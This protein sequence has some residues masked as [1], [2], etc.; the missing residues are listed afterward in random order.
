M[1]RGFASQ[2]GKLDRTKGLPL[3]RQIEQE[4]RER[5]HRGQIQPGQTLPSIRELTK[6]F[7]V[8]HLT[9]R[10]ALRILGEQGIVTSSQGRGTFVRRDIRTAAKLALVLPNL[11]NSLPDAIARGV[12]SVMDE[13]GIGGVAVFSSHDSPSEEAANVAQ[14]LGQT[15]QGLIVYSLMRKEAV[16]AALR[17]YLAGYPVVWVDRS[18]GELPVWCATSDNQH[19][20]YL[21]TDHLLRQG[22]QRIAF[23]SEMGYTTTEA[24]YQGYCQALG[25]HGVPCDPGLVG[26]VDDGENT[27]ALRIRELVDRKPRP[28]AIF[29]GNDFRAMAGLQQIKAVGLRVPDDIAVVGFDDVPTA[30]LAD[31]PLTTVR[32]DGVQMGV[33][34]AELFLEQFDLPLTERLAR[35]NRRLVPVELVRRQSA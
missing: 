26:T 35:P 18:Y 12:R 23:I 16:I 5:I 4:L 10:Q 34:A 31:P 21:A 19:G 28:D 8:N 15:A 25:D 17:G 7:Q 2:V 30:A 11:A 24:R 3:Y 32:Q 20:G 33:A 13:H 27:M 14:A 9:V 6:E 1:D 29:F 22:R